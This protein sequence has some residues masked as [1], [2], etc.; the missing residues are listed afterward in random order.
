DRR[1]AVLDDVA[2]RRQ[3]RAD[4]RVVADRA[5]LQRHVEV[6]AHE[7]ALAGDVEVANRKLHSPFFTSS[8]S[9]STQRFE[10]PHSLSYHERTLTKLPSITFVYGASMIDECGL[11]LKS[12]DTSSS[13]DTAMMPLSGPFA[14]AEKAAFTSG[15]VAGLFRIAARSTSET[16]GVGTRTEMPSSLPFN[17]GSTSPTATAAPVVVG[18]IESAAARAR[19]RSLCGRSSSCWSFVYEW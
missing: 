16:F 14:A 4:A 6:D 9:R 8:R 12:I 11:P 13:V 10:Y 18:I 5:V 3:R 7:H 19:R 1:A 15:A 2:N 17:S